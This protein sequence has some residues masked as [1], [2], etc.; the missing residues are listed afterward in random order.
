MPGIIP[1][2]SATPGRVRF[3]GPV[4]IGE[5]N[6]EIYQGELGLSAEEIEDLRKQDVI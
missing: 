6:Q 4:Q 3:P 5:H 2:F 1:K